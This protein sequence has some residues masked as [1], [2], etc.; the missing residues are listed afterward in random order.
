MSKLNL[1]LNLSEELIDYIERYSDI[2]KVSK[3]RLLLRFLTLGINQGATTIEDAITLGISINQQNLKS[4]KA[5]AKMTNST[6]VNYATTYENLKSLMQN[7]EFLQLLSEEE[8][9]IR[10]EYE[11]K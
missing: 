5:V 6:N 7:P 10:S 8:K 1:E 4:C 3:K 9:R 11:K 2:T